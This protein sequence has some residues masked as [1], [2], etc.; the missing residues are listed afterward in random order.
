MV[1][2]RAVW[3]LAGFESKYVKLIYQSCQKLKYQEK[4]QQ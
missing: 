3:N 4:V 1:P 2:P